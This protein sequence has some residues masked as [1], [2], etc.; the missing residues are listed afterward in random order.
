MDG[1]LD[2]SDREATARALRGAKP[3]R[4]DT[5]L[6]RW[7]V[8]SSYGCDDGV[9]ANTGVGAKAESMPYRGYVP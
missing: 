8:L 9:K 2:K 3:P 6:S 4:W 7:P 5:Y 1:H